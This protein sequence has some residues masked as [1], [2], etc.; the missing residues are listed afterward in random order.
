VLTIAADLN[1]ASKMMLQN[2]QCELYAKII[3]SMLC[4]AEAPELLP[5]MVVKFGLMNLKS[6]YTIRR[7]TIETYNIRLKKRITSAVG[8][9][10]RYIKH[11]EEITAVQD[12]CREIC[13]R[14][15]GSTL[16]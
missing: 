2:D 14:K 10:Q 5:T 6:F 7:G 3:G 1:M 16:P 12:G 15:L 13:T 4:L 11:P 9:G 8:T